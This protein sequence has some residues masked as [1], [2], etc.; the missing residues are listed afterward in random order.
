MTAGPP[1]SMSDPH[2]TTSIQRAAC[3]HVK[4]EVAR[5]SMDSEREYADA[6]AAFG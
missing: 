6:G 5:D 3:P 4:T 1:K 2:R